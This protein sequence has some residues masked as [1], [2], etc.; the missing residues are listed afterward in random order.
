MQTQVLEDELNIQ[1]KTSNG[2]TVAAYGAEVVSMD[3]MTTRFRCSR[4]SCRVGT[5]TTV[6]PSTSSFLS[7][8]A[9]RCSGTPLTFTMPSSLTDWDML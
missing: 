8:Q 2:E 7:G 4:V 3:V 6:V 9:S 1:L 5:G